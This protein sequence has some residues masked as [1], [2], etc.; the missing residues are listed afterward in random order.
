[1]R[2]DFTVGVDLDGVVA[3]YEATLRLIFA[4]ILDKDIAMFPPARTWDVAQAGW[5]VR[6]NAHFLELHRQAVVEHGLFSRLA[7]IDGA[8]EALWR[9]SDAGVRIRIVTH[10][11]IVNF[12]HAVTVSDTVNW[13]DNKRIPYRDLCFVQDKADIGADLYVDDSPGNI[14]ALRQ[15]R[16]ENSAMIY[17]QLY[18]LDVPGLRAADWDDVLTEV[19]ER[20]GLE[21]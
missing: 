5:P 12:A 3:N 11:L 2:K 14:A 17:T 21:L 1:M 8:S 7:P 13:L 4:E 20:S 9:M 10:R 18:N 6:D 16:G 15:S 19:A